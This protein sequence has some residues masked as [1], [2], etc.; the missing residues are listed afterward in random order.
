MTVKRSQLLAVLD[1]FPAIKE[2]MYK[3]ARE[4]L[5]YHQTLI[6]EVTLLYTQSESKQELIEARTDAEQRE[7]TC[8]MSL[9]RQMANDDLRKNMGG[10]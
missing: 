5:A 8:Y 6:E 3:I 7:I 10:D 1:L 2:S 9:K 4:K